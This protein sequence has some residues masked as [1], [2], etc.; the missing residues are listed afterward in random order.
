MAPIDPTATPATVPALRPD[1]VGDVVAVEDE[2]AAGELD[3]PPTTGLVVAAVPVV[4]LLS[5][6]LDVVF[7]LV[8][9]TGDPSKRMISASVVCHRTGMTFAD[10]A[11]KMSIVS[12]SIVC[13]VAPVGMG[14]L[15][16]RLLVENTFV[17]VEGKLDEQNS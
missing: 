15:K 13:S 1:E 9:A 10:T 6:V 17:A 16:L 11:A 12:K 14:P 2:S 3:T 8:V 4:S 5:D 7:T